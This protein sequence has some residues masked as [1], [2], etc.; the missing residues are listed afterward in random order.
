VYSVDTHARAHVFVVSVVA[1]FR[2][3]SH[4][5][6]VC[7]NSELLDTFFIVIHKKK[8]ILLHWYHHVSVLLYCW[9]SYVT[10]AP[11]GILF[12]VMNYGVHSIMYFYYFLMAMQW[13]P[14]WFNPVI[15]TGAQISQMMVGVASTAAA[16]YLLFVKLNPAE[17]VC[18]MG[19]ENNVA[20][21]VMYGSYLLLFLQ[22]FVGR[23]FMRQS[24]KATANGKKKKAA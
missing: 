14:K 11:L 7:A 4:L 15:I 3:A 8:L 9:H 17:D 1:A 2:I 10:K 6:D 16:N 23:Y 21:L 12:C 13:K 24:N 20:A 19:T 5:F 18:Y 22:F